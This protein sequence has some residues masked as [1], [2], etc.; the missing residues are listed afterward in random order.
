[1]L[2]PKD[3]EGKAII[4]EFKVYN[5]KKDKTMED[6]VQTALQQ[7]EDK[8]Y[9]QVLVDRGIAPDKILKYGFVFEGKNVLIG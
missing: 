6:A 2:E 8:K 4:L 7:I 5:P 9:V 3:K 1:M